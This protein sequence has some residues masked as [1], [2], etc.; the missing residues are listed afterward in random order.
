MKK[1]LTERFQEL[2]GI[3]PLYETGNFNIITEVHMTG[4]NTGSGGGTGSLQSCVSS[5]MVPYGPA[6]TI[7]HNAPANSQWKNNAVQIFGQFNC[8]QVQNRKNHFDQQVNSGQYQG[9]N[10]ARKTAKRDAL[11]GLLSTCC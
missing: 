3:K 5:S 2:A 6:Y 7:I 8:N 11:A 9:N 4:S 1:T 10:L